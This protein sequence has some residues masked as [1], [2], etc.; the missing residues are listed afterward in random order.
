MLGIDD[1]LEQLYKQAQQDGQ[2]VIKDHWTYGNY[3]CCSTR[4]P[5]VEK[6]RIENTDTHI[7]LYLW[8]TLVVGID[9][10]SQIVVLNE[11][12]KPSNYEKK[13]I[14]WFVQKSKK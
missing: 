5:L 4:T 6:Y 11:N 9:L 7:S 2:A 3:G 8:R 13:I 12:Y 10:E 14:D 1:K